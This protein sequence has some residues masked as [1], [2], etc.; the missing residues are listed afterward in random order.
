MVRRTKEEAEQ[1]RRQILDAARATFHLRGVGN[2]SLEHIAQ[3]AGLT[4]GAIYWHFANKEELFK[5][6]CDEVTIALVDR[7]DYALLLD[8]EADPLE[9]VRN[10]LQQLVDALSE[11]GGLRCTMEILNFKCEFVGEMQRDLADYI[12]HSEECLAKLQQAY[13][14]A[15]RDGQL[16]AGLAPRRAALETLIFLTGLLRL[17]LL[18]M[19]VLQKGSEL[20]G[21]IGAH[22][23]GMRVAATA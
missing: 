19:P 3:A 18:G 1:T 21:V 20:K 12:E 2:T 13:Q 15:Q 5:A 16:R 8:P 22:V 6:M 4:R 7:M 23:D 17:R 11:D 9:R 14:A 10:F